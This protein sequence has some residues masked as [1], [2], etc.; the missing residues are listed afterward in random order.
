MLRRGGICYG[1]VEVHCDCS[2]PANDRAGRLELR[3][4]IEI[5]VSEFSEAI[6]ATSIESAIVCQKYCMT[7]PGCHRRPA[8]SAWRKRHRLRSGN[9]KR[10]VL[11]WRGI[12]QL[13]LIVATPSVEP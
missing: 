4:V 9:A 7:V 13:A 2:S 11:D 1:R 6:Q 10:G 3:G 5:S 8:T 12:R